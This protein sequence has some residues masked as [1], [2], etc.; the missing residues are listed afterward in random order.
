MAEGTENAGGMLDA[1]KAKA[2]FVLGVGLYLLMSFWSQAPIYKIV[3]M[4]SKGEQLDRRR[5]HDL[6]EPIAPRE[7]SAVPEKAKDKGDLNNKFDKLKKEYDEKKKKYDDDL[8]HAYEKEQWL[9]DNQEGPENREDQKEL[10]KDMKWA[11][12]TATNWAYW[13]FV[14]RFIACVLMLVGLGFTALNGTDWERAAAVVVI[15]LVLIGTG[16]VLGGINE[17]DLVRLGK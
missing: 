12:A 11:Q 13:A 5:S 17:M 8:V 3:A 14:G 16:G 9:W 2:V 6:D 10:E 4:N 15:G 1:R 7:P